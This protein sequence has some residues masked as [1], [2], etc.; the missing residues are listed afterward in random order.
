MMVCCACVDLL[1]VLL[2]DE[3]QLLLPTCQISHPKFVDR[4]ATSVL[5]GCVRVIGA[6]TATP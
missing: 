1:A 6:L 4:R 3:G 5:T 2:S